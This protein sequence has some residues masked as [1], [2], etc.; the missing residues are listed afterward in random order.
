MK[1]IYSDSGSLFRLPL[2]VIEGYNWNMGERCIIGQLFRGRYKKYYK[3]F[4]ENI[5]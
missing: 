1:K 4:M 2:L 3:K 5:R